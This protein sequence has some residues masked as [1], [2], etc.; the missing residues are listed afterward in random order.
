MHLRTT[1]LPPLSTSSYYQKKAKRPS[2]STTP[3]PRRGSKRNQPTLPFRKN[4]PR[5][6]ARER[7]V[8]N[9]SPPNPRGA[10]PD[11]INEPLPVGGRLSHFQDKWT[12]SP[13][14]HSIV[15]RGLGWEWILPP[16]Q[17]KPFRQNPTP[18]L[19]EY[20]RKMLEKGV[21]EPC[22]SLR[23]QGHLF[24]RPKKDPADRRVL[25]DLKALNA[26]I[27]RDKFRQTTVAHVRTLLPQGAS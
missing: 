26:H 23:F 13:W 8:G 11:R 19:R 21:I 1:P 10:L 6:P 12:F 4:T 3:K 22:R 9:V 18:L 27:R 25:L 20:T 15:S 17:L 24:S 5:D 7:A 14:A 16:P 2:P